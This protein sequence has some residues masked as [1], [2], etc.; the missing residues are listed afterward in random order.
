MNLHRP[1]R[2]SR[3][4]RSSRSNRFDLQEPSA[5]SFFSRRMKLFLLIFIVAAVL[6]AGLKS[7]GDMK[8]IEP[9]IRYEQLTP[10]GM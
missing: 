1:S 3:P 5:P 10:P 6:L 8:P 4:N 9:T 2:P 7:C